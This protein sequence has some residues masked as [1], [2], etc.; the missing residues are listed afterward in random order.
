MILY[1]QFLM[2]LTI[3]FCENQKGTLFLFKKKRKKGNQQSWLDPTHIFAR[4]YER[5]GSG[6][7]KPLILCFAF[8]FKG[9]FT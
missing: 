9:R 4:L 3:A 2:I 5:E 7:L 1:R 8:F 6:D